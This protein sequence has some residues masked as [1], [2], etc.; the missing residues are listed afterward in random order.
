MPVLKNARHERFAQELAKGKTADEAR[1]PAGFYVYELLDPRTGEA[2][3]VGKGV[4]RR[5]WVHESAERR[6]RERNPFKAAVLAELRASGR[7]PEVRIV[8][9]GMRERDAYRLER[10]MIVRN[11]H[12]LTNIALGEKTQMEKIHAEVRAS[13]AQIKPLCQLMREEPS[14]H[15]RNLWARV[16][17]ELA[18]LSNRTA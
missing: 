17:T 12:R 10:S 11:R 2:F 15:R 3:Y 1:C 16:V 13:L 5:A 8:K 18:A 7:S 9:D 4:G 6:G 14:S